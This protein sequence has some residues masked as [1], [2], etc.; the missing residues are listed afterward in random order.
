MSA[1]LPIR[2]ALKMSLPDSL[3]NL[4]SKTKAMYVEV[5]LKNKKDVTGLL[6]FGSLALTFGFAV[7]YLLPLSLISMNLSLAMTI[8]AGILFGLI[9]A[10]AILTINFMPVLER[11][12]ANIF[13]IFEDA[14]TRLV[15]KKN[16]MAHRDRNRQTAMIFALALGLT[17][18]L[19]I[20][21]K[22]PFMV[23]MHEQLKHK[24]H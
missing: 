23:D 4:K 21:A 5:L 11:V 12:V 1:I 3:D 6:L 18:F 7:Y 16:L 13:L 14:S 9:V 24:G 17:I 19:N 22:I 2:A 20:V 8:F 15:V 10:L